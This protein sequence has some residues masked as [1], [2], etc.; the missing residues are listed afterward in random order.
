VIWRALLLLLVA[1]TAKT[2][3]K[4]E[5][6]A[7]LTFAR[8][9]LMELDH[10]KVRY[11]AKAAKAEGSLNGNLAL[12]DVHVVYRSDA[13]NKDDKAHQLGTLRIDAQRGR[14]ESG[15][16]KIAAIAF[17]GGVKIRDG[18]DRLLETE[19]MSCSFAEKKLRAPGATHFK[20]KE[21]EVNASSIDG[22]L[23][24][25]EFTLNGPIRGHFDPSAR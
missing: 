18:F 22:N 14:I 9:R 19:A 4:R 6:E 1:C 15:E 16:P 7:E 11:T 21:L 20:S 24:T 2:T 12:S 13:T 23:E 5:P 25:Q 3:R 10:G 17:E 8:M